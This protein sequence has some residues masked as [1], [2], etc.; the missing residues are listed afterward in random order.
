MDSHKQE[1]YPADLADYRTHKS[2]L[3]NQRESVGPVQVVE[4]AG[5]IENSF[6]HI[7]QVRGEGIRRFLA[8]QKKDAEKYAKNLDFSSQCLTITKQKIQ[9]IGDQQ[10]V[11]AQALDK[12]FSCLNQWAE[13]ADI[14][15]QEA[16]LLQNE[17]MGCQTVMVR[18]EEGH[19]LMLH[20]EEWFMED[21]EEKEAVEISPEWTRFNISDP[22]NKNSLQAFT[23]YAFTLPGSS[24]GISN[25][26][27]HAVDSLEMKQADKPAIP[28]N[29]VCWLCWYL[30]GQ[31][32]SQT[33]ID[34]LSPYVGGYAYNEIFAQ[35]GTV[36]AQTVEFGGDWPSL[37]KKVLPEKPESY[38]V[39]TN[40]IKNQDM[41]KVVG[42][43]LESD[44]RRYY[45]GLRRIHHMVRK[46]F[47]GRR[48]NSELN[49]PPKTTLDSLRRLAGLIPFRPKKMVQA[50]SQPYN[51]STFLIQINPDGS[52]SGQV[53]AGPIIPNQN[54]DIS[55]IS[56]GSE[57]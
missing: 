25:G 13:G 19:V 1:S 18:G 36:H 48:Q 16:F 10:P 47:I 8:F 20:T 26:H 5:P 2:E 15:E 54:A 21:D 45:L 57:N 14:S 39:H 46:A 42:A 41:E 55:S 24:F 12:Y 17:D 51:F 53:I 11:V 50:V 30:A 6:G 44:D 33:I 56:I 29:I 37:P 43:K 4:L 7:G 9:E 23:G 31:V 22:E 40:L 3:K 27:V 35:K 28:A 49:N 34:T 38:L 52:Y 32:D